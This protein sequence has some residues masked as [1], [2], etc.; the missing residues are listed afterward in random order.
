[1]LLD[2]KSKGNSSGLRREINKY[3]IN[4]SSPDYLND[5]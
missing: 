2:L 1:M 4:K 3:F 5:P